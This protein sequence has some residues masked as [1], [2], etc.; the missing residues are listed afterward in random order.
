MPL[1]RSFHHLAYANLAAQSA[2]QLSLAAVPREALGRAN[3]RIELAR[4]TAYAAGPALAGALVGWL[5]NAAVFVIGAALSSG[6]VALLLR[7]AEPARP[8]PPTRHPLRDM[9]EG[10]GFVW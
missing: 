8:L 10:A 6:A 7:I 9:A 3:G 1:S 2:E 4:S 5:G